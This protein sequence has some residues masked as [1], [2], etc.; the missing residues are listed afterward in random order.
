MELFSR[1]IIGN[2]TGYTHFINHST[3]RH[4]CYDS[5][6][7][8]GT[9]NSVSNHTSSHLSLFIDQNSE[10]NFLNQSSVGISNI[11]CR[12]NSTHAAKSLN[13]FLDEISYNSKFSTNSKFFFLQSATKQLRCSNRD[14]STTVVNVAEPVGRE[15][16]PILLRSKAL[17]LKILSIA[18]GNSGSSD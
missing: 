2:R 18:R 7:Q 9:E 8:L 13:K 11:H 14:A 5:Y 17:A 3:I 6:A 4:S 10:T 16:L 12:Q 15:A 1:R